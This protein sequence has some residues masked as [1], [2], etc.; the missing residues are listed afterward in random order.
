MI[1]CHE[2]VGTY[3]A[4]NKAVTEERYKEIVERVIEILPNWQNCAVA[5]FWQSVTPIQWRKIKEIPEFDGAIVEKIIAME[6][7]IL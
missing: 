4:F 1:F 2:V 6:L 5:G 3:H 7:P